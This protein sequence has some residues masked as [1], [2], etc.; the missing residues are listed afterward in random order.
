MDENLEIFY[1][2]KAMFVEACKNPQFNAYA[3]G[4]IST[5][6]RESLNITEF[7]YD[8]NNRFFEVTIDSNVLPIAV[9]GEIKAALSRF[10]YSTT[11]VEEISNILN[12]VNNETYTKFCN[13]LKGENSADLFKITNYMFSVLF[14]GNTPTGHLFRIMM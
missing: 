11:I 7:N 6:L 8:Y 4:A 2:I 9:V 10:I 13:M 1:N 12:M 5:L 14:M 3:N